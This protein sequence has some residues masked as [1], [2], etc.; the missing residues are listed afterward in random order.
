MK[1]LFSQSEISCCISCWRDPQV[2]TTTFALHPLPTTRV[3]LP[4]LSWLRIPITSS[5][6]SEFSD[7]FRAAVPSKHSADRAQQK[8]QIKRQRAGIGVGNVVLETFRPSGC[9][10][11]VHIGQPS[12][13]R[14]DGMAFRSEE[15]RVGKE[16][17]S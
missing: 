13:P 14:A 11:A 1:C 2:Q 15:R 12:Q 8:E 9:I 7:G 5:E 10:S 3:T 6:S 4:L 16:G 17:R